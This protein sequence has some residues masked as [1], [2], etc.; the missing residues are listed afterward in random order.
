ME[1]SRSRSRADTTTV[2]IKEDKVRDKGDVDKPGA[3]PDGDVE[4]RERQPPE[5][6]RTV[7][8]SGTSPRRPKGSRS[9]SPLSSQLVGKCL[10]RLGLCRK[11][12]LLRPIWLHPLE[13]KHLCRLR[14]QL[15]LRHQ[16]LMLN[17][18]W[19]SRSIIRISAK[20]LQMFEKPW[21]SPRL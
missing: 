8:A 7:H 5:G 9:T 18:S 10:H 17:L 21:R 16:K 14:L 19:Q 1:S 13:L 20:H 3:H 12:P 6:A 2:K 15:R 4:P 11:G